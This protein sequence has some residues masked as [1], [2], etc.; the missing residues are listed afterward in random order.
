MVKSKVLLKVILNIFRKKKLISLI[1]TL[2]HLIRCKLLVTSANKT[3]HCRLGRSTWRASRL[4]RSSCRARWCA[5]VRRGRPQYLRQPRWLPYLSA[6]ARQATCTACRLSSPPSWASGC[7]T[8]LRRSRLLTSCE[9]STNCSYLL[10]RD[11]FTP[12]MV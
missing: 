6:S 1:M 5:E 2:N 4:H 12:G 3:I 10:T 9:C 7:T 8:A 11:R